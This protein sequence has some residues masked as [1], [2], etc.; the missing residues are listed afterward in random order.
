MKRKW[1]AEGAMKSAFLTDKR[2]LFKMQELSLQPASSIPSAC[3]RYPFN[4]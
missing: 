3:K 1:R 2:Y 4:R